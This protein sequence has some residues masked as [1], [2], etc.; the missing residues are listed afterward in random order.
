MIDTSPPRGVVLRPKT[1]SHNTLLGPNGV[2]LLTLKPD[3][4][5]LALQSYHQPTDS[6]P[7]FLLR[8]DGKMSWG[9]K[10]ST[11]D[12]H[13]ER[14]SGGLNLSIPVS[15]SGQAGIEMDADS[16][17][18]AIDG[19]GGGNQSRL[20]IAG[21][22]LNGNNGDRGLSPLTDTANSPNGLHSAYAQ[23]HLRNLAYRQPVHG[24]R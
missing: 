19:T 22:T 3:K 24:V 6:F 14:L 13:L 7:A 2:P 9:N 5:D 21:A 11:P 18:N 12:L 17:G 4:D 16:N 10:A 20:R 8:G 15:A 1:T 23:I